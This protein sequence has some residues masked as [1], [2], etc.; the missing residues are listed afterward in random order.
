M[1]YL[2]SVLAKIVT[3]KDPWQEFWEN[4]GDIVFYVGIPVLLGLFFFIYFGLIYAREEKK[5]R[6]P[7]MITV[8]LYK[9]KTETISPNEVYYPELPERDGYAFTGWF[10][11]PSFTK[12]FMPGKKLKKDITLYPRWQKE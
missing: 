8:C 10:Y 11:D 7:V 5:N 9:F 3:R 4:Y 12:P 1:K 2:F 6:P